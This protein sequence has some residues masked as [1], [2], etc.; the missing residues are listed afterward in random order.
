ML[1]PLFHFHFWIQRVFTPSHHR[2]QSSH[3][4]CKIHGSSPPSHSSSCRDFL[5]QLCTVMSGIKQGWIC[6]RRK[7]VCGPPPFQNKLVLPNMCISNTCGCTTTRLT[8]DIESS[9]LCHSACKSRDLIPPLPFLLYWHLLLCAGLTYHWSSDPLPLW[10]GGINPFQLVLL[11]TAPLSG[12]IMGFRSRKHP[13][14]Q[15]TVDE[16]IFCLKFPAD[17]LSWSAFA[18]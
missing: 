7:G 16:K 3:S 14:P 8:H 11:S 1:A 15:K 5:S 10:Y 2:H 4:G 13:R 18:A 9:P 17:I 6:H 12:I